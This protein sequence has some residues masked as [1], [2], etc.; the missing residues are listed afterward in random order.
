MIL[1]VGFRLDE[2]SVDLRTECRAERHD[3]RREALYG[4]VVQEKI[5]RAEHRAA[6]GDVRVGN[7][8]WEV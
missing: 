5:G 2:A 1:M 6:E 4:L 7:P 3:E 8:A